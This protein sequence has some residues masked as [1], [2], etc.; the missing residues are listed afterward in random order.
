MIGFSETNISFWQA[1]SNSES[2]IP[3]IEL[4]ANEYE[5]QRDRVLEDLQDF[6]EDLSNYGVISSVAK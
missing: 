4:I 1:L 2:L 5:V 6:I 3:V